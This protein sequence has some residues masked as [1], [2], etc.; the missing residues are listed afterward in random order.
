MYAV[1]MMNVQ[2]HRA[3][4][5]CMHTI[6]WVVQLRHKVVN[7]SGTRI[8]QV[9]LMQCSKGDSGSSSHLLL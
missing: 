8:G 1:E 5:A 4:H 6:A 2:Q 7:T 3:E 9:V